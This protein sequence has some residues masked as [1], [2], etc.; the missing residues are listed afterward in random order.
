M[1]PAVSGTEIARHVATSSRP[2]FTAER[3]PDTVGCVDRPH[4]PAEYFRI[5]LTF[6]KPG[7]TCWIVLEAA[8]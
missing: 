6:R 1:S 4:A 2:R 8:S 3:C 7:T 5:S